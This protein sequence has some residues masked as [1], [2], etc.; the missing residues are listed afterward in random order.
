M[1]R[2]L[3]ATLAALK[4]DQVYVAASSQL[5]N[6]SILAMGCRDMQP[7]LCPHIAVT[8]DIDRR[9][10]FPRGMLDADYVVLA[11]PTQYHVRPEDQRVVGVVARDIRAGRGLG[12]FFVRLPGT[13]ALERDA[14]NLTHIL[15]V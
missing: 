6:S 9:D 3:L 13:F 8:Q 15:H 2:R 12:L 5:I 7:E 10:G 4:P 11:T 14:F 1:L